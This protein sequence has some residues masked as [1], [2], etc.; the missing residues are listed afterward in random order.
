MA[1]EFYIVENGSRKGPFTKD[2]LRTAGITRD[3]LVWHPAL[4]DWTRAGELTELADLF[5]TDDSAFG[6]YAEMPEEPYFAIIGGT[7]TGPASISELISR[8]LNGETPVWRNGM[9]DWMPASSRPDIMA[10][11]NARAAGAH[12]AA[13][14]GFSNPYYGRQART[15][16]QPPFVAP[17]VPPHT[18][19]YGQ[20]PYMQQPYNTP[21]PHTNWL[22]WAILGTILG[23]GSCVGLI[24]GIIGIVNANKANTCYLMNDEVN[25]NIANSSAKSMTLVS[26]ILG[27]VSV[28]STIFMF[29]I[30]IFAS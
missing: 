24:F 10:E 26:L 16:P 3:T 13:G 20:Q 9:A 12:A 29:I 6:T 1:E 27:A 28:I 22:P 4:T 8:G 18:A 11:L 5:F 21:T 14:T 25:G 30:G 7:Q 17:G 23:L 19:P 15:A 2:A